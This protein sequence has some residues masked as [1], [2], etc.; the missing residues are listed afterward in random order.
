MRICPA[1]ERDR[2][3]VLLM[4]RHACSLEGRP[5]PGPEESSVHALLPSREDLCLIACDE[6]ARPLGAAWCLQY[7]PPL[8]LDERGEPL[9]EMALAIIP[10]ARGQGLGGALIQALV[11]GMRGRASAL[12]LNLHLRNP[13]ARLYIRSG[14]QVAG[15]GR[16]IYG[17]AMSRELD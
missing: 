14:F 10:E 15:A 11:E 13:A 2:E 3:F 9:P 17:V 6:R 16:G 4:A 12:T 1:G 8:L 5:L 7:Q